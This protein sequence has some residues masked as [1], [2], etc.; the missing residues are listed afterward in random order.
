M[1]G[2]L[3]VQPSSRYTCSCLDMYRVRSALC[4]CVTNC[5]ELVNVS[6]L[7]LTRTNLHFN[8]HHW[9][10]GGLF[11]YTCDVV[12][13]QCSR[14][15]FSSGN[16]R[17]TEYWTNSFVTERIVANKISI[18]KR[19]LIPFI[20][21]SNRFDFAM[22]LTLAPISFY[23]EL[24]VRNNQQQLCG[25]QSI[26]IRFFFF[27]ER[28]W[29]LISVRTWVSVCV[30]RD[31]SNWKA[32]RN[33]IDWCLSKNKFNW[34]HAHTVFVFALNVPSLRNQCACIVLHIAQCKILTECQVCTSN[35]HVIKFTR[36]ISG[37]NATDG[38]PQVSSLEVV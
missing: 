33:S 4:M 3:A 13:A 21:R 30:A 31:V 25:K 17:V 2:A 22:A 11:V 24:I 23:I 38:V 6:N 19:L 26:P 32:N 18:L 20:A 34:Y 1:Y 7:E 35:A 9:I 36:Q 29:L 12:N 37:R 16:H 8:F 14:R 27:G 28:S 5:Y 15:S 10:E